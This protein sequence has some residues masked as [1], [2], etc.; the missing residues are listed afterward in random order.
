MKYCT[1]CGNELVDEAAICPKCGCFAGQPSDYYV[2]DFNTPNSKL[3]KAAFI[4][5]IISTVLFGLYLLPLAW[6]LPMTLYYYEKIKNGENVSVGFKICS[7]LF[8]SPVA[9][10]LMLCDNN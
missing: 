6:C 4:F 7:L 1:K 9:G 10:I 3:Q 5:M 8:V 2:E